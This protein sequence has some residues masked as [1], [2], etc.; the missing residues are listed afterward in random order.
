MHWRKVIFTSLILLFF[1]GGVIAQMLPDRY[2]R[3][4]QALQTLDSLQQASP[5]ICKL[6]TMGYS[7]RDSVPMLRFKIS[8]NVNVDEDEPAVFY[9]GGVHA[10]EVLGVEVV[11]WFIKDIMTR[12][13]NH[14]SAAIN[15]IDN[16]EI[17][18]I[19]FIN[20]EGHIVVENGD[21][22]WRKNKCDNDSNGVFDFHDG[23][24]NNRNYDF[25]WSID[26]E[27]DAIVPESLQY[28]GTAPFTQSEN[29]AMGDFAWK[30]RPLV[31]LDYHSPT[32]G[33]A[34]KAYYNW[35]WYATDGGDGFAPDESLMHSICDQYCSRILNDASDSCYEARR[36]LV[37]KGD[38]KTYF[39]ANF[40]TVSFSVE[41]SDTT[42]QDPALVD[43][44]C[45]HHLPGQYYLLSRALGP[46]ITGVIKDSVTLEPI[47]AEVRVAEAYDN[48][49]LPRL[50]RPDNGRYRRVL[51]PG[52]YTLSFIKNGYRTRTA[53][54]VVVHS[55][56]GPT[57][58]DKLL[59]PINPRPPAPVLIY[60]PAD[61]TIQGAIPPFVW[62][63]SPYAT[64][65]LFEIYADSGLTDLVYMDS[66][67]ADT[68]VTPDFPSSD[69]LYYWRV[70]G[71]DSY[72]WGPYSSAYSLRLILNQ[73]SAPDL[74]YPPPDTTL[75]D[76]LPIFVWRQIPLATRYL[77]EIYS[78][79][80]LVNAVS[81]DSTL[82]DT[83]FIAGFTPVDSL[84]YWRVKGGDS[85]NWGPYSSVSFFRL[86]LGSQGVRGENALPVS[87]SLEQNYPNPFNMETA[88]M[89][90]VP[91]GENGRLEIFDIGG[92]RVWQFQVG[93]FDG[94][95]RIV[96]NGR[97]FSGLEVKSGI[98]FYRLTVGNKSLTEKMILL[99]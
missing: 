86:I 56:G 90:T 22:D 65:Y 55:S 88:I 62:H 49:I 68:T 96:W 43:T 54:G 23:V 36:G 29:R 87:V 69:T 32:Y 44:I 14:D 10:D 7:T 97:D 9:C 80:A 42:I 71:G 16:L 79:S 72:G 98:Y 64:G 21:T 51:N 25:G 63:S 5:E 84:Y 70:K 47:E 81:I 73:L 82:T 13:A 38:F 52:T 45:V 1:T 17:F 12:Y 8:D 4:S 37:N 99:K 48:Y 76:S 30:Y 28:K 95:Q 26:Q 57:E 77:F 59:P 85:L 92:R 66:T 34:E 15:Y 39:Y 67:V 31:A 74:I 20:P 75:Y 89:L 50:S 27:P 18:C 35:Y 2:T 94:E 83:T 46:G 11:M 91:S 33:R 60:P 40:G 53:S 61:T 3:Y 93:G 78:D 19:P 24:D 6:D 58:I 41:I